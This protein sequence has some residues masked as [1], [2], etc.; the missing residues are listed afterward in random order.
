MP[1]SKKLWQ[2]LSSFFPVTAFHFDRP[3]VLIQSDDW[4]RVGLRDQ[5]GLEQ[6][7]Y[8]GIT[9][10]DRPYDFYTLET[11][12]DLT[13]LSGLL[14]KHHDSSGRYACVE[15]NF[16]T[17]NLDFHRAISHG[18]L[19]FSPLADGLPDGWSRP[20]LFE[21]YRTGIAGGVFSAA[22]HGTSHFCRSAVEHA[23]SQPERAD[24]LRIFWSAGTPYI[25]WRMPWVGYEY[26]DPTKAADEC[27][28]DFETQKKFISETVGGFAKMFSA[29]PASACAPGYRA[30]DD[31]HRAWSEHG[32]RVAQNGPGS[33]LPP[34]YGRHGI[35][36]LTRTVEF[37]P[38]VAPEFSLDSCID[39]AERCFSRGIPAIISMHSINFHSSVRDF[40]S[41]TLDLLDQ[42]LTAL[43]SR[44]R[45]LL[46]L[47]DDDVYR[48]IQEGKYETPSG[49][50]R[51]NVTQKKVMKSK[52]VRSAP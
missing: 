5:E 3:I 12:D 21:A 25:H 41:R 22:L 17:A 50:A 52:A 43:E 6:L 35:L 9:L 11:A 27:F 8:A 18:E 36:H 29:L 49:N 24:L 45:D 37:E 30:N 44:H 26:W 32:I 48:A 15:M 28:L 51:L 16:I 4:G 20:G 1:A 38:A 2:R 34:Y 33:L 42:F 14:R 46:Y 47:R 7:R 39:Q 10:R 31:T 13:A 23:F 40:R 19:F